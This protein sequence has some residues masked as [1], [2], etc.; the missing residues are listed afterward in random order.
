MA[1]DSQKEKGIARDLP[2]AA[3]TIPAVTR[4]SQGDAVCARASRLR[5]PAPPAMAAPAARYRPRFA[6]PVVRKA[7]SAARAR[8]GS[9]RRS[10]ISAGFVAHQLQDISGERQRPRG[11]GDRHG[12]ANS[13]VGRRRSAVL[14]LA[15][16]AGGEDQDA[17]VTAATVDRRDRGRSRPP[18]TRPGFPNSGTLDDGRVSAAATAAQHRHRRRHP[19]GG[20]LSVPACPDHREGGSRCRAGRSAAISAL[21]PSGPRPCLSMST[22]RARSIAVVT[23]NPMA[24]STAIA[25]TA[26]TITACRCRR[27]RGSAR[28]RRRR[29]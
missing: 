14:F 18:P 1:R 24:I 13:G 28:S 19:E 16:L 3:V 15:E 5:V 27:G 26:A 23:A 29:R 12:A 2:S 9:R 6:V 10:P 25:T 11:D 7:V 22:C 8:S 20:R 17:V 4:C 21:I